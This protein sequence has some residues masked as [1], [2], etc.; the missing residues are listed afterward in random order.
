MSTSKLLLAVLGTLAFVGCAAPAGTED[1]V[2]AEGSDEL[3]IINGVFTLK[4]PGTFEMGTTLGES[5]PESG[6][7]V[8][9]R[10]ELSNAP[11]ATARLQTTVGANQLGQVCAIA[12]VYDGRSYTFS[13][14][15]VDDCGVKTFTGEVPYPAGPGGGVTV[16]STIKVIDRRANTC[17][18]VAVYPGPAAVEVE[19]VRMA[20]KKHFYSRV[21]VQCTGL[22]EAACNANPACSA[23][24]GPSYCSPPPNVLCTADYGYKGCHTKS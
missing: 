21:P 2:V 24:Y 5:T 4:S 18:V 10:L 19:E 22:G 14:A 12:A 16:P 13:K 8:F 9:T 17:P 23:E 7:N 1:E 11:Y 6:C 15:V 3:R 20:Q